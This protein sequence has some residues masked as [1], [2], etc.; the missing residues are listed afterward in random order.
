MTSKKRVLVLLYSQTGQ[1]KDVTDE[2]IAPLQADADLEVCVH[3]LTPVKP[4]PYPWPF[5]EFMDAF[6][7]SALMR[8]CPMLPLDIA[9]NA[10]FDLII[11]PYQV[12]YLAPSLPV[13]SF[14][15]SEQA[16]RLLKGKPVVTVIACRN[17]WFM[18]QEKVKSLL[19][20]MGALLTD[21]I[22]LTDPSPTLVTLITT[23]RWLW[24]GKKTPFWGFPAAGL[25]AQQVQGTCRFGLALRDALSNDKEKMG[26]PMLSGL[27]AVQANPHLLASERAGTHSFRIW[28]GWISSLGP[29]GAP[30]RK[31]MLALYTAFLILLIICV[32]PISLSVQALLRPFMKARFSK[33]KTEFEQP[34]G[35]ANDRM[36]MF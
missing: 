17:M 13:M 34:S 2:I 29:P 32:V 18:A 30:Q 5:F 21:N 7:E 19:K 20:D 9:S 6:P 25:N 28:G 1:L 26:K 16:A 22:V 14:L 23:P 3:H 33:L 15:K 36:A 27:Q 8:P 12:W 24:F 11:L 35:S 4:F 31:P 10:E